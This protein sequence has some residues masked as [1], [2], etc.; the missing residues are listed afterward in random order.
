[1]ES[2]QPNVGKLSSER[3]KQHHREMYDA[4]SNNEKEEARAKNRE[5]QL[6]T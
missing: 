5:Y 2:S 1:M 6:S 3:K 4:L